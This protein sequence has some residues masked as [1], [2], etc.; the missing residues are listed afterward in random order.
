MMFYDF[1]IDPQGTTPENT[2]GNPAPSTEE[3]MLEM[4]QGGSSREKSLARTVQIVGMFRPMLFSS[5]ED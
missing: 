1:K 2:A 5:T 4:G 3:A